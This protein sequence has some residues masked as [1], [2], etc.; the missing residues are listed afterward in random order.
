MTNFRCTRLQFREMGPIWQMRE[1]SCK[2]MLRWANNFKGHYYCMW[3][4]TCLKVPKCLTS[5]GKMKNQTFSPKPGFI[6]SWTKVLGTVLQYSYFSVIS[7]F[8]L[9]TV[10]PFRNF[11]A[12]LPP[13]TLYKVET[14]KKILDTRVQHCLWGEGR[15]WTCVNWKRPRNA[16]VSQDFCPWL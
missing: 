11:L 4:P 5:V 7:R 12:V 10:H 1:L 9:K 13:P 16:K 6:Q 3:S 8:P 15:G 2:N 14:R